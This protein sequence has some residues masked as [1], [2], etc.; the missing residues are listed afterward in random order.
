VR[1]SSTTETTQPLSSN[2]PCGKLRNKGFDETSALIGATPLTGGLVGC[3]HVPSLRREQQ[4]V[5]YF[6]LAF[7]FFDEK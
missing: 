2:E 4:N 5:A 6:L 3:W 1:Q 7:L